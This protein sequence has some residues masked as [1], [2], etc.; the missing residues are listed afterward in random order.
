MKKSFTLNEIKI[1]AGDLLTSVNKIQ[2]KNSIIIALSGELGTGKTTLTQE[3]GKL[4][5]IKEKLVSPTFVIM[6]KY[7]TK[8]EKYKNLIHID[9]YRLN[10]SQELLNLGWPELV[11]DKENLIIIEWPERVPECLNEDICKV[12]LGHQDEQTR[13]I[14]ILR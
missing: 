14:E 5:G 10:N 12:F 8:N 7:K 9:A 1:V 2:T 3:I 6:K 4:L 11:E 13:T